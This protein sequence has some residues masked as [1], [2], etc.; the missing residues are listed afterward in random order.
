MDGDLGA[1][2]SARRRRVTTMEGARPAR[3]GRRDAAPP[4]LARRVR[5]RGLF[6]GVPAMEGARLARLGRE[7]PPLLRWR[8]GADSAGYSAVFLRWRARVPRALGGETPPLR[9]GAL[10]PAAGGS[11]IRPKPRNRGNLI[12]WAA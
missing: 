8:D 9:P 2:S 12:V 10:S 5:F 4:G 7:T 1:P 3:L 6:G 11:Y